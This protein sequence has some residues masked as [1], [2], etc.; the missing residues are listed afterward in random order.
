[1]DPN[2]I[3][4]DGYISSAGDYSSGRGRKLEEIFDSF[5]TILEE[6]K[7]EAIMSGEIY[8]AL[9]EYISVIK[10]LDNQLSDISSNVDTRCDS[11]LTAINE[12]DSYL[13]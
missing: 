7:T 3:I 13:F 2:L 1:M 9:E 6:I 11:F 10:M 5:V 8:N 12:A 4:D